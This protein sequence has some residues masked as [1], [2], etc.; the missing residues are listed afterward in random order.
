[1][2]WAAAVI[3]GEQEQDRVQYWTEKRPSDVLRGESPTSLL[4]IM[5]LY[6]GRTKALDDE[7]QPTELK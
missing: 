3:P 5:G 7:E 1:M 6:F 4:T 2:S